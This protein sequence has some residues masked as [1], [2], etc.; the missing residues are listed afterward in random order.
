MRASEAWVL[1]CAKSDCNS[2][3]NGN[4]ARVSVAEAARAFLSERGE[5]W[6]MRGSYTTAAASAG[7]RTDFDANTAGCPLDA[8]PTPATTGRI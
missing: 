1:S 8:V 2:R 5:A 4:V 3:L 6:Q 7:R